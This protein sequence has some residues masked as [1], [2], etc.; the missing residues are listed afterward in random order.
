[1]PQN[2]TLFTDSIQYSRINNTFYW[3][4]QR[5]S[6]LQVLTLKFG[7]NYEL[8]KVGILKSESTYNQ[9][10]PFGQF[11]LNAGPNIEAFGKISLTTGGY[12]DKDYQYSGGIRTH[13]GQRPRRQIIFEGEIY[14]NQTEPGY[15]YHYYSSISLQLE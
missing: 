9:T 14:R 12:N 10:S 7:V 15:F 2:Q 1:M 5:D 3:T 8:V 4:N 11:S 6:S 13:F